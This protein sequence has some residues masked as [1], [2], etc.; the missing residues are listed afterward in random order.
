MIGN[1][2]FIISLIEY[3]FEI[4]MLPYNIE[5][6]AAIAY[7]ILFGWCIAIMCAIIAQFN[8]FVLCNILF[9]VV[10]GFVVSIAIATLKK[11]KKNE[12]S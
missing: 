9:I 2:C 10:A 5:H 8:R 1:V 3:T 7:L 4:S 11:E 6:T 12:R